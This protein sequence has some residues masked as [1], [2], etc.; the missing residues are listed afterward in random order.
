M[1]GGLRRQRG[2][3]QRQGGRERLPAAG[4]D[5]VRPA[6]VRGGSRSRPRQPKPERSRRRREVWPP[7]GEHDAREAPL[8]I[9]DAISQLEGPTRGGGRRVRPATARRACRPPG[10][11]RPRRPRRPSAGR[12]PEPPDARSGSGAQAWQPTQGPRPGADG[13]EAPVAACGARETRARVDARTRRWKSMGSDRVRSPELTTHGR[14]P[15]CASTAVA[16]VCFRAHI[17]SPSSPPTCRRP[18]RRGRGVEPDEVAFEA[19]PPRTPQ[20]RGG[21]AR[22][23][24]AA[25]ADVLR[26]RPTA[27][28]L[29]GRGR[30]AARAVPGD[31]ASCLHRKCRNRFRPCGRLSGASA[32]FSSDYDQYNQRVGALMAIGRSVLDRGLEPSVKLEKLDEWTP[33][34]EP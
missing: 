15:G 13:A 21:G 10:P 29:A 1:V 5:E 9:P 17:W 8:A 2:H 12:R 14:A 31:L 30:D 27:T 34:R 19:R 3:P 7:A 22:G 11:G 32:K 28:E 18:R 25:W 33:F 4:V 16:A 6:A 20:G 23:E 26:Q 24:R